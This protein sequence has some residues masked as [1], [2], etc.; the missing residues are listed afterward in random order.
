MRLSD[1]AL[2]QK[3]K[4]GDLQAFDE[5]VRRYEGKIYSIAFRFMGNHADAGDLAQETFI[6]LY[7]SLASFR[8]DSAFSTWLYRIA[9]NAC[10]DELRKRQRRCVVSIEDMSVV[11]PGSVPVAG[12]VD[13][14]P[15]EA[16]QRR[17][18][19][20]QIQ[21]CL[22]ELSPDHRLI[23]ILREILGM[24]YEEIAASLNCSLGTVKSRISRARYNLK[25]KIKTKEELL[26][27]DRRLLGKGGERNALS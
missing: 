12:G 19:Q 4:E 9:A 16:V 23:L 7:Q 1:E 17:E 5:L 2:V 27:E 15:E 24:S 6:R 14:S 10:R 3:S 13:Y 18:V 26:S 25:E 20:Q 11:S 22:N 21:A 8:G